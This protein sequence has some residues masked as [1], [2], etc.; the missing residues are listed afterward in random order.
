MREPDLLLLD[1]IF[2]A[3]D[4]KTEKR[5]IDE[6]LALGR[7]IIVASHRPSVL[8]HCDE[9]LLF[10]GGRIIDR[11]AYAELEARHSHLGHGGGDG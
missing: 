11:G 2:S 9:V 5:L 4:Q 1:D 7:T 10:S 6:V 3:V 8:R